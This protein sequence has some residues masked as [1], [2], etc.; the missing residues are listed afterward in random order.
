VEAL[1]SPVG[2]IFA[3]IRVATTLG[4]GG[5]RRNLRKRSNL[6]GNSQERAKA[7]VFLKLL[8]RKLVK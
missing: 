8:K 4:I 6:V 7:L 5:G 3:G 1:S 2:K